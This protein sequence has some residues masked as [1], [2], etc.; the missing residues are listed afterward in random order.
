M[1]LVEVLEGQKGVLIPLAYFIESTFMRYGH[2]VGGIIGITLKPEA[3]K[4]WALS[5]HICCKI[6][7]DMKEMEEEETNTR[8]GHLYHKQEAKARVIADAKDRVGLQK[9]DTCL[10]PLDPNKHPGESIVNIS[11]KKAPPPM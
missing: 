10:H 3:L 9:L 1:V 8:K 11:G 7:S 4:I 2:S 5:C 6:E